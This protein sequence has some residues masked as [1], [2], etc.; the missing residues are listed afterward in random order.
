MKRLKIL[1]V[2]AEMS[3]LVK[4]GGLG[5]VM[6]SLPR[7]LAERG[8][9]V[10]VLIP[11][12][13]SR[14]IKQARVLSPTRGFKGRLLAQKNGQTPFPVWLLETAAF[15]RR[16]GR[17][18]LNRTGKPWADNPLQFSH[19]SRTAA[20]I[21]SGAL[22]LDWEPDLVHC[23][24]WHTGLVP[25]WMR[26][27]ECNLPTVFTIH[28]L[29]YQGRF[30]PG[31]LARLG[32]PD[33]LY[34]PEALEF[35]GEVAFIKGGLVFADRLTTVSPGYAREIQ[36]PLF[37]AG[38]DGLLRSRAEKL[39]GI[40]NGLDLD[41][42]N[43]ATD[44]WLT[45][46]FDGSAPAASRKAKQSE[47][48]RLK[49]RL[50]MAAKDKPRRPL[51]AWVG[52]LV[53]QKGVDILLAALPALMDRDIDVVV[54]G[55]G[56]AAVSRA[57]KSAAHR[58]PGRLAFK[59][60]FDEA[61]AHQVYAASDMLLMPSRFEPCGLAQ[62]CAMRYGSI[63]VVSPVGGLLDTV[64]D[65]GVDPGRGN[66]FHM[67]AVSSEKLT[68]AVDRALACWQSPADWNQI[69]SNAMAQASSFGWGER[70]LDY[71]AVYLKTLDSYLGEHHRALISVAKQADNW[72]AMDNARG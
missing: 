2:A 50:G 65:A 36:T 10:R 30:P 6:G 40:V 23:N 38:L 13:S 34:D 18:Y 31:I 70:V 25:V 48:D 9:D 67:E 12:Y 45:H 58:W 44:P 63:P 39:T 68:E 37:G 24:D 8:H 71:E 32:L 55:D 29:A 53:E 62:L 3:P 28:N 52:R 64:I 11:A 19:L 43:P 35:H 61:L 72:T 57:L 7:A 51:L 47:G 5:E 27:N 60:G 17:P 66:G 54:L 4:V 20:D 16:E 33:S 26:M 46:H 1:M 69:T 56:E 21:A 49:L 15:L 41:T 59:Q 14:L 42:W 22:G